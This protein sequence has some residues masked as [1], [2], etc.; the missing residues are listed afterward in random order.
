MKNKIPR[1]YLEIEKN[2]YNIY[3]DEAILNADALIIESSDLNYIFNNFENYEN[4]FDILLEKGIQI[5]ALIDAFNL[6]TAYKDLVKVYANYLTGFAILN[7]TVK[8]LN[9]LTVKA[10]SIENEMRLDFGTLKFIPYINTPQAIENY[11]KIASYGR[12]VSMHFDEAR[13][14]D[15][16]GINNPTHEL[17][18]K[19]FIP[20]MLAKKPLIL[21]YNANKDNLLSELK[22]DRE[23]GAVS[24]LTKEIREL[25]EINEFY[26]PSEAEIKEAREV[27]SRLLQAK[28][29]G[30]KLK[31]LSIS[32]YNVITAQIVLSR[33]NLLKEELQIVIKNEA[34]KDGSKVIKPKK[35]YTFG[36]EIANA[37]TH[38]IGI[39][40]AIVFLVLLLEKAK[41]RGF[42]E[43]LAYIIYAFGV[44]CLYLSSTLYHGLPLGTRVKR[45]FHKFDRMSIYLL[46]AGTY[47]PLTL[48]VIGGNIGL[49]LFVIL[50]VGS[51]IGILLN[52]IK[53]G[54]FKFVH[55]F[56]YVLL[57][58][59]AIFYIETV[60]TTLGLV[61]SILILLGGISYTIGIVFYSLKLFKFTHMVWHIFTIIGTVLHF[62]A[63]YLA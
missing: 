19:I 8:S 41:G 61:P 37:I 48:V 3:F 11:C 36:E 57:G 1:S 7:T 31:T 62:I 35:F 40:L 6:K 16:V 18:N 13:F 38:G 17:K 42:Y 60:F 5:Y 30:R 44:F 23:F 28:K 53:F 24:K 51:L 32:E 43:N 25:A 56:L 49:T 50:W 55:M 9:R 33:S 26:T 46:I 4:R 47:T 54:K 63:I 14:Y 27:Y 20:A 22:E 34:I 45:L 52:F 39:I 58:W 2:N 15:Y 10:R 29:E 21:G 59:I 12:V